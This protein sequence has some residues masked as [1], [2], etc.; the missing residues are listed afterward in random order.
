M[1]LKSKRGQTTRIKGFLEEDDHDNLIGVK[2]GTGLLKGLK[3]TANILNP[4]QYLLFTFFYFILYR[5]S[6]DE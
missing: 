3:I 6:I 1:E 2:S 5:Y 4:V